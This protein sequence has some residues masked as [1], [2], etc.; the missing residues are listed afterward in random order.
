MAYK[1]PFH[2]Y[3]YKDLWYRNA[4]TKSRCKVKVVLPKQ[5]DDRGW[6]LFEY[7]EEPG[8]REFL[9]P[10]EVRE[11]RTMYSDVTKWGG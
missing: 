5:E 4:S 2:Y 3:A 6:F 9:D 10:G 8:K 1:M 7:D 11:R